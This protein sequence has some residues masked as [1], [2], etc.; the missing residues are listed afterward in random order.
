LKF[1]KYLEFK[2]FQE[3]TPSFDY[4][5]FLLLN[6]NNF[7]VR[8]ITCP[9]CLIVWLNLIGLLVNDWETLGSH[10][11]LSWFAYFGFV[12]AMRKFSDE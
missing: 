9:V 3:K 7:F 8:L 4:H 5:N 10:V 6:H 12:W 1:T 2:D 11:V